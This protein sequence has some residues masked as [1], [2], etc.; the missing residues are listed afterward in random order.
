MNNEN[1]WYERSKI[2]GRFR[3]L[4]NDEKQLVFELRDNPTPAEIMLWEIIQK[5]QIS[6]FKFRQQHKIGPYIV[7]FYCH[8]VN[9][10]IEVDGP[11][12]QTRQEYD[13]NR[14]EW[15]NLIG[16]KVIR[17]SNEEVLNNSA[18]VKMRILEELKRLTVNC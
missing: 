17:F 15:L 3:K 1:D 18:Q 16:V 13:A 11:I 4:N 5:K 6:G 9:L 14:T 2:T 8:S 7:D 10:A 12:H